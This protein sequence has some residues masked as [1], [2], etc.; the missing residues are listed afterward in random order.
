MS[1][2][3]IGTQREERE[4]MQGAFLCRY[5]TNDPAGRPVG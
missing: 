4:A 1:R 5:A 2:S 3:D